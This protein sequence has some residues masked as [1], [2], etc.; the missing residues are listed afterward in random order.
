MPSATSRAGWMSFRPLEIRLHSITLTIV[1]MKGR[2][3]PIYAYQL[4]PVEQPP[5]LHHAD[6]LNYV[7][8]V[9]GL[10]QRPLER[11]NA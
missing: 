5:E 7:V 6:H 9:E 10:V 11:V 2:G 4:E 1:L 8:R 3:L